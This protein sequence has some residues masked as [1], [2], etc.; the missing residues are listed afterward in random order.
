MRSQIITSWLQQHHDGAAFIHGAV[1]SCHLCKRQGQVEDLAGVDLSVP[2]QVDQFWQVIAHRGGATM[3]MNVLR[4][5]P[6]PE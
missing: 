1:A 2:D 5:P 4:V 6:R 3:Q